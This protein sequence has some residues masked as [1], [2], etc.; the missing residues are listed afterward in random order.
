MVSK[1]NCTDRFRRSEVNRRNKV[2]R[3]RKESPNEKLHPK[4]GF[5]QRL[6]MEEDIA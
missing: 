3:A 4:C 6:D 5:Y 2:Y 1:S